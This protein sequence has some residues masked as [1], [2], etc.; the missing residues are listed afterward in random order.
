MKTVTK[1]NKVYY[2]ETMFIQVKQVSHTW[3]QSPN[4]TA[5]KCMLSLLVTQGNIRKV[6][7]LIRGSSSLIWEIQQ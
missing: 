6:I 7:A 2:I 1:E 4:T 5:Q 3:K